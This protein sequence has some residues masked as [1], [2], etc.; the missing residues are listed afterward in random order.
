MKQENFRHASVL[1][2][3]E[4]PQTGQ[5]LSFEAEGFI[6]DWKYITALDPALKQMSDKKCDVVVLDISLL[7]KDPIESFKKIHTSLPT[8]PIIV[9]G[10][11][12]EETLAREIVALGAVDYLIEGMESR[13][14]ARSIRYVIERQRLQ[15]ELNRCAMTDDLTGLY[16][17][18]GL[19]QLATQHMSLAARVYGVLFFLFADFDGLRKINNTY[20]HL[21]GNRA[22]VEVSK[23]LERVFRKSD[24]L[25]RVGGDEFVVVALTNPKASPELLE[26]RLMAEMMRRNAQKDLPY[27]LSVSVGI[28]RY[29][30]QDHVT[31]E[32]VLSVA[33]KLMYLNKRAKV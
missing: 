33:D 2:V 28:V 19:L 17:R 32:Q 1:L 7:G 12:G 5:L 9:V 27:E 26:A 22:L 29:D 24:I 4:R 23:V 18:R 15:Q 6:F 31:I 30:P 20:G 3:Q 21:E 8:L 11:Q 10:A 13:Y 25:A 14:W 16:N